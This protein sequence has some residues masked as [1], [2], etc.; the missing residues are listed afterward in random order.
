LV[1]AL[2]NQ[3]VL[4]T[5]GAG[6]LG[7]C[8]GKYL[9]NS[10]YDIFLGSRRSFHEDI[11]PGCT[12]IVTDWEEPSLEFCKDFDV[13]IH[14]AGMNAMSCSENPNLALEFNGLSTERLI[15]KAIFYGC[16]Q[17]FYLSTAHVYQNPL[18]GYLDESSL[19]LNSHPYA[20]SHLYGEQALVK[21]IK[22]GKIDGAVLRL[23][24]CFGAPE[25]NDNECWNLALN[26]FVRDAINL[27]IITIKGNYLSKRD[28]LPIGELNRVIES[29]LKFPVLPSSVI[30]ISTGKAITLND[31]ALLISHITHEVTGKDIFIKKNDGIKEGDLCIKSN[32]LRKMNIDVNDDL[33]SEIK[34]LISFLQTQTKAI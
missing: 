24:N 18:L 33:I 8:I 19:T 1:G 20:T 29:I 28:F 22:K 11:L 13:V 12:N 4:I 21:A 32:V 3:R 10:G 15:D 34:N 16:K 25:A 23:S 31:V 17:F 7:S 14:A 26:Q 6:Y 9:I 2:K 30:N 27:G 5:G